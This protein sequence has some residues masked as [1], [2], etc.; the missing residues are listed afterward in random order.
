MHPSSLHTAARAIGKKQV[1]ACSGNRESMVEE[2]VEVI[3]VRAVK[4]IAR[5]DNTYWI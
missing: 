2:G 5:A 4:L 1:R 3:V